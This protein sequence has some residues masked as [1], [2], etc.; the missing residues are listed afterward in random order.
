[1]SLAQSIVEIRWLEHKHVKIVVYI[2]N[3]VLNSPAPWNSGNNPCFAL[4]QYI[5]VGFICTSAT[6]CMLYMHSNT[7][8]YHMYM[9][10]I[11][12]SQA[13]MIARATGCN[14]TSALARLPEHNYLAQTMP[15]AMHILKDTGE[16]M[17]HLIVSGHYSMQTWCIP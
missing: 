2:L 3:P 12:R 5:L 15:D 13:G 16:R 8:Y 17:F 6:S 9:H 14:V 4:N 7:L 11:H 1:M 10:H